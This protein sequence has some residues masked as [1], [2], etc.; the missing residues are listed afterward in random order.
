[1]S[2]EHTFFA[3]ILHRLCNSSKALGAL[4]AARDNRDTLPHLATCDVTT[5]RELYHASHSHEHYPAYAQGN[6]LNASY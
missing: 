3:E 5:F 2:T 6:L 1:M 4:C